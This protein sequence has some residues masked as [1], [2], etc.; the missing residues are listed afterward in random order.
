MA[1][2]SPSDP[3]RQA[4]ASL[5]A[6]NPAEAERILKR[7]VKEQPT[8]LPA[9]NVLGIALS[10]VGKYAEAER[11]LA[12][13]VKNGPPSD[14]T[15]YNYG[16][17]LKALKKHEEALARFGEAL[18]LNPS[19]PET[20]N[21]RG[22]VLNDLKRFDEA[23]RDFDKALGLR[24]RYAEALCN[25]GKSLLALK[26]HDQALAAYDSAL[27]I[28][29]QLAEAYLGRGG[30]LWDL[31]RYEDALAAYNQAIASKPD[32]AEAW[33][34]SANAALKF[35]RYDAA[36]AASAKAILLR[37]DLAEAW[38][39]RGNVLWHL[40]RH[41]EAFDAYSKATDLNPA[42]AGPW[43]WRGHF[44]RARKRY[45]ESAAAFEKAM[46][47]APDLADLPGELLI[48]RLYQADWRDFATLRSAVLD[49]IGKSFPPAETTLP[50]VLTAS[51]STQL[52]S[53]RRYT[54]SNFPQPGG[55]LWNGERY[56]HDRIRLAYVSSDL[57]DHPVA[58]L[59]AGVFEHHDRARFE[60]IALSFGPDNQSEMLRRL[61]TGFDQFVE[62]E[63]KTDREMAQ[64]LR[65]HEIDIAIDLMGHTHN[66]RTGVFALRPCPVQVSYLGYP[67]TMGADFIDYIVA[68]R[69]VIP[70]DQ[71]EHY[72][73]KA[74]SLPD[75]FQA[76]D[77]SRRASPLA[78][79]RSNL[80]LPESGFVFC[81]FNATYKIN[82][83]M[84]DAWM[85]I[86]GRV[87]D[88]VLWLLAAD[89]ATQANLR[90]A[91][92]DRDVDPGRI[93]FAARVP[94]R[95]Y[96]A[97]YRAA[98][99]FL[100]TF[101]FNAGTTASDAL[102]SGLPLVTL[103]GEA[104]AS[105]MAGSLLTA[106]AL[107]ELIAS[108]VDE[109]E[110]IAVRVANDP[111]LHT[112]I[113]DRLTQNAADAAVFDTARFTRH[114]ERAYTMMWERVQRGETPASFHVDPVG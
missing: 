3:F 50:L 22:T 101:P 103:S 80:G 27:A 74:A 62:A 98:D 33:A 59:M 105:R 19:V 24:P 61:R 84:F 10:S 47:L 39:S 1:F 45:A 57:H 106:L 23:V 2:T 102:W 92:T 73:E 46:A 63:P 49:G 34:G 54:E 76:N 100:D 20:W 69:F 88:S 60:T 32:L 114:L 11:Y 108:A 77:S 83:D 110:E 90:R 56:K 85:R 55:R 43:I 14:T 12:A 71:R 95:D 104:F 93:V 7:L 15:L 37:P 38:L 96:L 9:L 52:R 68:D 8:H 75:C 107:P 78:P 29:R 44:L 94:Y 109:Y 42:F 25:K 21:N 5:Q 82:P 97:R 26:S 48:T 41:D 87:K 70:D 28:N 111:A 65:D 40:G 99:L 18:T 13:A 79:G 30:V 112:S 6:G 17:I 36:L 81:A 31:K 64:W 16:L 4:L 35:R 86:L 91:A 72:S 53:S 51:A 66:A 67:A 89:D 113:R 58:Y